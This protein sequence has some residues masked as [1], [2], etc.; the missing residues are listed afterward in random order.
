M[1][2]AKNLL[3]NLVGLMKNGHKSG[4]GRR[5]RHRRAQKKRAYKKSGKSFPF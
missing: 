4:G 2:M 3:S 1:F 5:A